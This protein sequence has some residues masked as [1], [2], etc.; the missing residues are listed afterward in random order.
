MDNAVAILVRGQERG[1]VRP[2][3]HL[4]IAATLLLGGYVSRYTHQ[5]TLTKWDKWDKWIRDVVS[6]L[7]DHV[8]TDPV[9]PRNKANGRAR[10]RATTK[11]DSTD[12][13]FD[14]RGVGMRK[15]PSEL[16]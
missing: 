13:L 8:G 5:G 16:G 15:V 9:S 12:E 2:D 3:A 10:R 11:P 6:V 1:E 4:E 14:C 7:W